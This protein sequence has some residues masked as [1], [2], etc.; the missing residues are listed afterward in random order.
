MPAGR[1]SSA[2]R[3]CA[4]CAR[5]R[6]SSSS[7]VPRSTSRIQRSGSAGSQRR[8][9][10]P[11]TN[12]RI[13]AAAAGS[14]TSRRSRVA[15]SI[16]NARLQPVTTPRDGRSGTTSP[17]AGHDR[18]SDRSARDREARRCATDRPA[19]ARA[20]AA[21]RPARAARRPRPAASRARRAIGASLGAPTVPH[22]MHG[23]RIGVART[24]RSRARSTT[25]STLP[26]RAR[27]SRSGRPYAAV[28]HL[29]GVIRQ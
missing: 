3:N 16:T 6:G 17:S 12:G 19:S 8:T 21:R 1:G 28:S 29:F 24:A 25:P 7:E 5:T 13:S 10:R 2:A 27:K 15:R 18:A 20:D 22:T 14:A 23:K 11:L 26:C 9:S 4:R